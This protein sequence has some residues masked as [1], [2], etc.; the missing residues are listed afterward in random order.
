MTHEYA[1]YLKIREKSWEMGKIIKSPH[2]DPLRRRGRKT[3]N[4]GTEQRSVHLFQFG[5][6]S[7]DLESTDELSLTNVPHL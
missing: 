1:I 4:V 5:Y 6:S 3:R 2:P 7:D